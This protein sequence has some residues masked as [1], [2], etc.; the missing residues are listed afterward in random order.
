MPT[1]S[2]AHFERVS[3]AVSSHDSGLA[4]AETM[5]LPRS[6]TMKLV[7]LPLTVPMVR[8][9]NSPAPTITPRTVA[10]ISSSEGR[11]PASA[12]RF[13]ATELP[14]SRSSAVVST[15]SANLV[16]LSP[17]SATKAGGISSRTVS[18]A[19]F[20]GSQTGRV[21][22]L[23]QSHASVALSENQPMMPPRLSPSAALSDGPKSFSLTQ[24]QAPRP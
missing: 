10:M 23:T 21:F 19:S 13:S 1:V 18:T 11:M 6:F 17:R 2:E 16:I 4:S 14:W 7:T 24:S 9:R 3:I 12:S 20:T 5:A 22:S 15:S 8:V